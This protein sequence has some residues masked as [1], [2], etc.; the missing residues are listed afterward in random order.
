MQ[1]EMKITIEVPDDDSVWETYSRG[2]AGASAA[3]QD[4]LFAYLTELGRERIRIDE[5]NGFQNIMAN[6]ALSE[7]ATA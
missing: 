3:A 1:V 7:Y 4:A 6:Y 5:S 2:R